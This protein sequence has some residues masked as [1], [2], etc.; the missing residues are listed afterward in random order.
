METVI[1]R[2]VA[3]AGRYEGTG[4]DSRPDAGT[5]TFSA[6]VEVRPLVD[7][8]GAE[9]VYVAHRPD[10]SL[11]HHEHTLLAFDMWSGEA[12]LYVLCAEL[13]GLG[14]L[15]QVTETGFSNGL[16]VDGFEL[17]V[18]L[19]LG[20]DELEHVWSWGAP[21]EELTEQLR[22]TVSRVGP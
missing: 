10:G 11:V 16:G 22:A 15:V 17:H 20:A 4:Q 3:A 13:N 19:R 2:V 18:E 1:D 14:R 8:M 12:T 5:G 9:L 6:S 7:G 21:G